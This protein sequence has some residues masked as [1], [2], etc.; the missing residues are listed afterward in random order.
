[1]RVQQQPLRGQ[2]DANDSSDEDDED[3]DE[4]D[5][6]SDDDC[7]RQP[8]QR[9][10]IVDNKY[11]LASHAPADSSQRVRQAFQ[12]L[13]RALLQTLGADPRF[14]Q[15]QRQHRANNTDMYADPRVIALLRELQS[16]AR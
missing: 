6:D 10:P 11:S 4:D 9:R 1:M 16:R 13:P 7:A 5:D 12:A 15:L 2:A 8:R 3:E 14:V